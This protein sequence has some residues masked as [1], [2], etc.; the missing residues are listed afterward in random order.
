MQNKLPYAAVRNGVGRLRDGHRREHRRRRRGRPARRCPTTSAS[1]PSPPRARRLPI[2]AYTYVVLYA[3]QADA[4]RGKALVE[5]LRWATHEGQAFAEPLSYA[6]APRA[7]VPRIDAKLASM[8]GPDQR[9]LRPGQPASSPRVTLD[10]P[11]PPVEMARMSVPVPETTKLGE[12]GAGEGRATRERPASARSEPPPGRTSA[13]ASSAAWSPRSGSPSSR[14][15]PDARRARGRVA[16][17]DP[18]HGA[19]VPH[20]VELGSGRTSASAPGPS[21]TARSSL[22]P[23][24]LPRRPRLDRPRPSSSR[25]WRP[26]ASAARSASSW[27][28]WRRSPAW[29]TASGDL[30]PRPLPPRARRA[31]PRRAPRL[32]PPLPRRAARLRHARRGGRPGNHDRAHHHLNLARGAERR[33]RPA[34]RGGDR[35]RGDARG[36]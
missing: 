4:A 12:P 26:T 1:R 21:S 7:L 23:R 18:A 11:A 19:L 30:R 13:I 31:L 35:P 14:A 20:V 9:P 24:A 33:A 34:P 27:S 10:A 32:P 16:A 5:F 3:E 29:S 15:R 8:T 36:T 6:P 25:T 2:A 22:A 28:S 17:V